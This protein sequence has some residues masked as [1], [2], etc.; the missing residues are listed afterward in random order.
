MLSAASP[1][2]PANVSTAWS[3]RSSRSL[4]VGGLAGGVIALPSWLSA[5]H[6][7]ADTRSRTEPAVR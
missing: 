6:M 2:K 4:S 7:S 3:S 5:R 1:A